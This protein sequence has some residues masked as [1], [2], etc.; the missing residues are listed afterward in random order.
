MFERFTDEGRSVVVWAQEELVALR[1]KQIGTEHL[2]LGVLRSADPLLQAAVRTAGIT[3]GSVRE[4]VVEL[5]G[6]GRKGPTGHIP[7]SSPAKQVL[8]RSLRV[9]QHLGQTEIG[10]AHLLV[11]I[12]QTPDCTAVRVLVGMDVD[13]AAL[14]A[15]ALDV[16]STEGVEAGPAERNPD[17]SA[18]KL[19]DP[20]SGWTEN[21][22]KIVGERT[23][24]ALGLVRFARHEPQC[25]P[26]RGCSCGLASLLAVAQTVLDRGR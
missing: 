26:A 15:A 1:H 24:L 20:R 11:S 17:Q 7:F 23:G 19:T 2:L 9:S 25:D 3:L 6:S 12:L 8:E 4:R 16:A 5:V 14:A 22:G 18:R 13:I 10:P 21:V